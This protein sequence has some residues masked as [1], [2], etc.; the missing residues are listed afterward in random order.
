MDNSTR[1]LTPVVPKRL[2]SP[3]LFLLSIYFV[4]GLCMQSI[5]PLCLKHYSESYMSILIVSSVFLPF[6]FLCTHLIQSFSYRIP[7]IAGLGLAL[8]S[9]ILHLCILIQGG[10]VWELQITAHC[11]SALALCLL[12]CSTR[13]LCCDLGPEKTLGKRISLASTSLTLGLLIGC[14][15]TNFTPTLPLALSYAVPIALLVIF[16]WLILK[17]WQV[18]Q[19]LAILSDESTTSPLQVSKERKKLLLYLGSVL[20]AFL[21]FPCCIYG[22]QV[23]FYVHILSFLLPLLISIV[24]LHKQEW[25]SIHPL[26]TFVPAIL[27]FAAYS[28]LLNWGLLR[29]FTRRALDTPLILGIV[30]CGFLGS[31]L[32]A[33]APARGKGISL[34]ILLGSLSVA[35]LYFLPIDMLEQ[36][37]FSPALIAA[38]CLVPTLNRLFTQS[39]HCT[40]RPYY[41]LVVALIYFTTAVTHCI[42][43]H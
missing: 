10:K 41:P 28:G 42:L 19:T 21:I 22:L 5:I 13:C 29:I 38:F 20:L 12:W 17:A 43:I 18:P 3:Y 4:M 15:I 36:A 35:L 24:L 6:S 1:D 33:Y 30:L 8:I 9:S 25:G 11:I 40:S 37:L 2:R 27:L 23:P 14:L 32:S 34:L 31:V 7:F 26:R 16:A 39:L